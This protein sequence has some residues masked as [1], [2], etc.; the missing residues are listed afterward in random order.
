LIPSEC[1]W[2]SAKAHRLVSCSISLV[3]RVDT[4]PI[5]A[6]MGELLRSAVLWRYTKHI[7]LES[8]R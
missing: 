3:R 5:L 4:F 2:C 8:K 6:P 1:V 7:H